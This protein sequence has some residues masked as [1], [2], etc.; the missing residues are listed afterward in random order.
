[1]VFQLMDLKF[2]F[3][4]HPK[5]K[6]IIINLLKTVWPII[7]IMRRKLCC[8]VDVI[9]VAEIILSHNRKLVMFFFIYMIIF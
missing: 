7:R 1:M 2:N 4:P 3:I 6:T 8:I 9:L 5:T